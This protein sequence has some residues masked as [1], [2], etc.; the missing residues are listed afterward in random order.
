MRNGFRHEILSYKANNAFM[1]NSLV[2][3]KPEA[4]IEDF[5]SLNAVL[6]ETY[7]QARHQIQEG[8]NLF[9]EEL[10]EMCDKAGNYLH[11]IALPINNF[12]KDL[13]QID[14]ELKLEIYKE[15]LQ[16]DIAYTSTGAA[17]LPSQAFPS[18]GEE[19]Y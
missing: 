18:M 13:S 7:T 10:T 8:V 14:A 2:L 16:P 12:L 4:L 1:A 6:K 5:L 17:T 15:S 11:R 19:N 9:K 3:F